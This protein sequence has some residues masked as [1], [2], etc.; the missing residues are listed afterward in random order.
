M[1]YL[2]V[3]TLVLL[4][5]CATPPTAP[6]PTHLTKEHFRHATTLV[7]KPGEAYAQLSTEQGY[8][9]PYDGAR[10]FTATYLVAS[11]DRETGKAGYALSFMDTTTQPRR[12]AKISY[13]SPE[14]W[15][16]QQVKVQN[17]SRLCKESDCWNLESVSAVLP[18]ALLRA[19]AKRYTPGTAGNWP[20]RIAPETTGALAYAEIA[21]LL[22]RVDEYR[23]TL[24][25]TP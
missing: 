5:G 14:G 23:A 9:E 10:E 8:V 3:F 11:V 24:G 13:E 25:M 20:F 12:Q 16:E 2:L 1:R 22:E 4:Y 19:Y 6:P 15:M 7:A 18:E 21:G 17:G